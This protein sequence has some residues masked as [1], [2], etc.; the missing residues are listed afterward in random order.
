MKKLTALLLLALATACSAQ[1]A[2]PPGEQPV[3]AADA[4]VKFA[5][6]MR[7][8][9]ISDY[10]DTVGNEGYSVK[11]PAAFDRAQLACATWE[12]GGTPKKVDAAY[13][14]AVT[15]FA[16]CMRERGMKVQDPDPKTGQY[17]VSVANAER[18]AFEKAQNECVH[19][20]PR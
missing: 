10:P 7:D 14:D 11:D 16:K 2:A 4:A 18:R 8:H 6:C 19:L 9:G 17:R 12:N 20:L 13:V 15:R 3:P 5:E 1:Q